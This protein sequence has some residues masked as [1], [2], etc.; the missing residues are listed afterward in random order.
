MYCKPPCQLVDVPI[1][2]RGG[3]AKGLRRK[4]R[5]SAAGV[6]SLAGW[7]DSCTGKCRGAGPRHRS[8]VRSTSVVP[9][10]KHRAQMLHVK[11]FR[12]EGFC[13]AMKLQDRDT[14][15]LY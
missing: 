14:C 6:T 11:L 9:L 7:V 1:G 3:R 10:A 4:D 2:D 12:E 13:D 15:E 8:V 5:P